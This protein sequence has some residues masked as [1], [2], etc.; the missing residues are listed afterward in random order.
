MASAYNPTGIKS[1][2]NTNKSQAV[3]DKKDYFVTIKNGSP[4]VVTI[5]NFHIFD[6]LSLLVS[7][8]IQLPTNSNYKNGWKVKSSVVEGTNT[9][10]RHAHIDVLFGNAK[11]AAIDVFGSTHALSDNKTHHKFFHMAGVTPVAPSVNHF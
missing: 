5:S 4:E 6:T 1:Y 11:M 9:A 10:A 3:Q 7:G 2:T 8:E